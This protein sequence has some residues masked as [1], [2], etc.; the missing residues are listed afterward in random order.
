M[1][2][3]YKLLR[4]TITNPMRLRAAWQCDA[5]GRKAI[6]L[7][8]L[9]VGWRGVGRVHVA[10]LGYTETAELGAHHAKDDVFEVCGRPVGAF[11]GR[12]P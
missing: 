5:F 9:K 1:I 10:I 6:V 4:T 8:K 11:E 3:Y 2:V 12:G 7:C